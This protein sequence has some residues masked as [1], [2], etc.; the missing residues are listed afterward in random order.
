MVQ[1]DDVAQAYA[2]VI[3]AIRGAPHNMENH[4]LLEGNYWAGLHAQ[5]TPADRSGK[6]CGAPA[7]DG[8]GDSAPG[9]R[10]APPPS[11]ESSQFR[12]TCSSLHQLLGAL[13]RGVNCL[14]RANYTRDAFFKTPRVLRSSCARD[15]AHR[16]HLQR[17]Q[18]DTES[19]PMVIRRAPVFRLLQHR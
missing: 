2:A 10:P 15:H 14:M 5:V 7:S 17:G 13:I 12:S 9:P 8:Q 19:R 4:L 11:P 1:T 3:K 16:D 6:Q 18:Q